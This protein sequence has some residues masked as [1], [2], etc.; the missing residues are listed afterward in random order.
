MRLVKLV[1]ESKKKCILFNSSCDNIYLYS[2]I[3]KLFLSMHV[4]Y[5]YKIVH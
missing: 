4:N 2:F 3:Q 5:T 1:L